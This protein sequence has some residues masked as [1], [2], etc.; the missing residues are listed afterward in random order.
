MVASA[1]T[2]PANMVSSGLQNYDT[3]TGII[4]GRTIVGTANQITVTNGSGT[5]GN[6]T[7]SLATTLAN[8]TYAY[9]PTAATPY[10]VLTS[11]YC[12]GIDCSGGAKQVNLPN[13]PSTGATWT[14]KDV[15]GSAGTFNIT[16]TTPG[17]A[18]LI[19]SAATYVMNIAYASISV[20]FTGAKYIVI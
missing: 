20:L 1:Y 16:L 15:T 5:A 6:P 13:A 17:G 19:D 14:I 18:V 4:T 2:N 9:T 8:I 3:T 11:D 10:T 12:I 7:L